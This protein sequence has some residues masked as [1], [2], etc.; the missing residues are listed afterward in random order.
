VPVRRVTVH[1]VGGGVGRGTSTLASMGGV[2]PNPLVTAAHH[3]GS[4]LGARQLRTAHL[5]IR[6]GGI[7]GWA[8]SPRGGPIGPWARTGT[9]AICPRSR[10]RWEGPLRAGAGQPHEGSGRTNR[11]RR[12]LT[13]AP[14]RECWTGDVRQGAD[15]CR[16]G[17]NSVLRP[18]SPGGSSPGRGRERRQQVP[19]TVT[20][21]RMSLWRP[22]LPMRWPHPA[23][24]PPRAR[25]MYA[26]LD[27]AG[28]V[29][30]VRS[31]GRGRKQVHGAPAGPFG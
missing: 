30:A 1:G 11:S 13:D 19:W 21:A 29:D 27:H 10:P 31:A 12:R 14:E 4:P 17:V 7:P 16:H 6:Y 20:A 18:A 2:K 24:L 8:P 23:G 26:H 5:G 9:E 25:P 3:G 28:Q 22:P 15:P